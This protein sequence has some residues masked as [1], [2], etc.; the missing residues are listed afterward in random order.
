MVH[1]DVSASIVLPTL[2]ALLA[3]PKSNDELGGELLDLF[4]FD[5]MDIIPEI[6]SNRRQ[7]I[8]EV[9]RFIS[10]DDLAAH[11]VNSSRPPWPTSVAPVCSYRSP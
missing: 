8:E 11:T 1:S 6:L 9:H 7:F 5:R 2:K 10:V 3:S 4:G